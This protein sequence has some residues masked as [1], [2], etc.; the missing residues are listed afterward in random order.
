M[1]LYLRNK[2][3][4]TIVDIDVYNKKDNN[5]EYYVELSSVVIID[6]YSELLLSLSKNIQKEC[7]QDFQFLNELRGWL[8]EYYPMQVE[9]VILKDVIQEIRKFLRDIGNKYGLYIVE[10]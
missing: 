4:K 3:G 10:D 9:V 6:K 7:I 8:W 2:E 5:G 1:V